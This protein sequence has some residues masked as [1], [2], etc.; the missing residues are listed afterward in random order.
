[1]RTSCGQLIAAGGTRKDFSNL[2]SEK[3]NGLAAM[4]ETKN[5]VENIIVK[6]TEKSKKE[7]NYII[8]EGLITNDNKLFEKAVFVDVYLIY[9]EK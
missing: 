9:P 2:L 1:M 3:N 6:K 5:K 7:N 4:I 8:E